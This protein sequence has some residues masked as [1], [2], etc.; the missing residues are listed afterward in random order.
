M[1]RNGNRNDERQRGVFDAPLR[2]DYAF[3][4]MVR[5][6]RSFMLEAAERHRRGLR[7]MGIT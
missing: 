6:K 4:R 5:P 7:L 2:F 1:I 3:A